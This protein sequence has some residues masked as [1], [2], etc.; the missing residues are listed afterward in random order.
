MR[1]KPME[2]AAFIRSRTFIRPEVCL[3]TGTGL[4]DSVQGMRIESAFDYR[5]IP[6]FPLS[7]VQ[8]HHGKMLLGT[9][10][11]KPVAAL[12]GRF[13]LYEG[14]RPNEV[15]F[16]VRVMQELGARV[17]ILSNAAGGLNL[18]FKAG[19]IMIIRD[20]INL[21]GENPLIGPNDDSWGPRF[22]DMCRAY[23]PG[24]SARACKAA[25]AL[26]IPVQQ[27]VYAGLSGPNLETPAEVRFLRAI[28]AD[29]VGFSTVQ[30]VIAAVHAGMHVLGLSVITNVHV[31]DHPE[32]ASVEAI[33]ETAMKAAPK[34][35]AII[36]EVVR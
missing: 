1:Q 30:E 12:Q 16:P 11:G 27:G 9:L 14:Y 29:S 32:P 36:R 33:I 13:H 22:P 21:T 34:L 31:P 6:H 17:L 10:E 7:T 25:E 18:G 28:G 4:G 35:S 2:A 24:L 20:H 15:V 19:E 5:E 8:S 26:G 3:L 23:D